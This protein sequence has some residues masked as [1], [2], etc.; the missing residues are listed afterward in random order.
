[1]LV[2]LWLSVV[3]ASAGACG[4]YNPACKDPKFNVVGQIAL[5]LLVVIVVSGVIWWRLGKAGKVTRLLVVIENR[6][7]RRA[8]RRVG[9]RP[10]RSEDD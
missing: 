9:N 3:P 5:A 7:V 8:T 4:P 2:F 1:L 6:R 10:P